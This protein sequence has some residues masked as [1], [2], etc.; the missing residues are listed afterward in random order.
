MTRRPIIAVTGGTGF[1]GRHVMAALSR[2]DLTIRALVRPGH[3]AGHWPD[4]AADI[5]TGDLDDIDTLNR[6]VAGVDAAVHIAGLIREREQGGCMRIN[7]DG[8]HAMATAMRRGAPLARFIAVS[9]IAAREPHLSAYAASK[10]AGEDAVS[11]VYHDAPERLVILRPPVIYGPGDRATLLIFKAAT[12]AVVPVFGTGRIAL[13]HAT[14]AAAALARLATG[15]GAPGTYTLADTNP[16]GYSFSGLV[17]E[18]ARAM[19]SAPHLVRLPG[20]LLL[21]AGTL[22]DLRARHGGRASLLTA[23]KAREILHP[24]WAVAPHEALPC[25]VCQPAI[26]IEAGFAETV[27]WY[28]NAGWLKP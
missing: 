1:L 21:A 15:A 20:S 19:G 25:E 2:Q 5:V 3:S 13:I 11:A 16:A 22:S 14:D 12:R 8:S 10:R 17:R 4:V 23:G 26:G 28:R 9:S 18:A 24:D 27:A 7:R 6:L